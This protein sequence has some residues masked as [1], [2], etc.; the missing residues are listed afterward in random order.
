MGFT[1]WA[2]VSLDDLTVKPAL[3]YEPLSPLDV[4]LFN[5]AE[6]EIFNV[7][8]KIDQIPYRI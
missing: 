2:L 5:M 6:K 7:R 8:T 3:S 1:C 4:L